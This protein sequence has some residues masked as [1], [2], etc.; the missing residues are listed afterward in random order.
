M[1][2][3]Q[4]CFTSTET[5]GLLRTDS[6][7]R[8]PDSHTAPELCFFGGTL[9]LFAFNSPSFQVVD[10]DSAA[11]LICRDLWRG[12]PLW[13]G[14]VL[15]VKLCKIVNLAVHPALSDLG[16]TSRSHSRVRQFKPTVGFRLFILS[17]SGLLRSLRNRFLSNLI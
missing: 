16:L 7:G 10:D 2:M 12:S 1:S 3:V 15:N 8:P 11:R 14:N 5:I 9:V 17:L 13:F 6:P 4:Y